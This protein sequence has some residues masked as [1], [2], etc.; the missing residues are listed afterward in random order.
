LEG[1]IMPQPIPE[2]LAIGTTYAKWPILGYEPKSKYR[3]ACPI[4]EAPMVKNKQQMESSSRCLT[5]FRKKKKP[6]VALQGLKR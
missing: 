1:E 3:T 5:C 6:A 4:C 2:K